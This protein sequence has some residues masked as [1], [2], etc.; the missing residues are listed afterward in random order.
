MS[1]ID[2][3]ATLNNLNIR[4]W[5]EAGQLRFSAPKDAMTE[6][7]R[8]QISTHK[9]DIIAFLTQQQSLEKISIIDDRSGLLALSFAQERLWFLEKLSP[10]NKSLHINSAF[11]IEGE[12]NIKAL[13]R[14]IQMLHQRHSI[15]HY[16]YVQ[17]PEGI[18]VKACAAAKVALPYFDHCTDQQA[19]IKHA[20]EI[21]PNFNLERAELMWQSLYRL[22]AQRHLLYYS[23]HH[24][25]G[26]GLSMAILSQELM[27]CYE[28]LCKNSPHM[29]EKIT[30]DYIDYAA[31]QKKL[32]HNNVFSHQA[33]YWQQQLCD[34]ET[35]LLAS[36]Y[37]RTPHIQAHQ[38]ENG[39]SYYFSLT[40]NL[41]QKITALAQQQQSTLF[42]VLISLWS[43]LLHRYSEQT[44]FCIGTPASN[45]NQSS[46]E[47][48][49]GCFVNMLAI[50]S[51]YQ[52]A[53]SFEQL[54]KQIKQHCKEAF[55][56]QDLPFEHVI[57]DLK[58]S[59]EINS[60]PVFQSLF[61]L[62]QE[63]DYQQTF[64]GISI[65][66]QPLNKMASLYDV[67]LYVTQRS[68]GS[69]LMELI[70]RH[71]LFS[72]S[73]I[74]QMAEHF[75]SLSE[76]L[77]DKPTQ[78]IASHS[79]ISPQQI[80][81]YQDSWRSTE[82][83]YAEAEIG[84]IH[85]LF[86][87]QAEKTPEAIA[88]CCDDEQLSYQ[89]LA[90]KSDSLASQIESY[91]RK[92]LIGIY[93]DRSIDYC[94]AMLGI[95]KTNAA[96]LPLNIHA[97]AQH[98]EKVI[99]SSRLSLIISDSATWQSKL[100]IPNTQVFMLGINNSVT[101]FDESP[102]DL[103]LFNLIYT[104]GSTG[105][106][107]G[108]MV[109]H[110]AIINRLAWMQEAYPLSTKSKVLHKTPLYFDVSVWEVFWPLLNGAQLVIAKAEQHKNSQYLADLIQQQ[111]IS[112]CHFVPA[113]LKVFID[114]LAFYDCTS[115]S[116][117]FSSGEVLNAKL[118]QQFAMSLPHCKLH[119]LY[120]PT[121]AAIDV[122][123]YDCRGDEST[124]PIGS[125][126]SNTQLQII[127][128]HGQLAPNGAIGELSIGGNN[129][130]LGYWNDQQATAKVFIDNP[131][132]S[133]RHPSQTLYKT[134][135]LAYQDA[136]GLLHYIGRNDSQVK[137]RGYRIEL[138][139]VSA[140]LNQLSNID[141]S[142]VKV[143]T[144]D[145]DALLIAYLLN[146]SNAPLNLDLIGKQLAQQLPSYMLP[147]HFIELSQW[148]SFD[149]G[150][151]NDKA[152][153]LP[154][155]IRS[156]QQ[157]YVEPR[158]N[159]EENLQG[160]WQ[161]LLNIDKIGIHDNFFELGGHSLLAVQAIHQ[162]Q[163]YFQVQIALSD[164]LLDPTISNAALLIEQAVNQQNVI[165]SNDNRN[166]DDNEIIL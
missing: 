100:S 103:T 108:V 56:H 158:N 120:G 38:L 105:D 161:T 31:W 43:A 50:K 113:M 79:L 5:L 138:S 27:Q 151:V 32:V 61:S 89:Q 14:S 153:P 97:P 18:F 45:R 33:R 70:Y 149:N 51:C 80:K 65:T 76:A 73:R 24:I 20:Q 137:I 127:N 156:T 21:Q 77:C 53:T 40:P 129:L 88:I 109:P 147:Q 19:A 63:H 107:K 84:N 6:A 99:H 82:K 91:G 1:V 54:L 121:E 68:D 29:L 22:S 66:A 166:D 58:L 141:D 47:K 15:M 25:A 123:Y 85:T 60:T 143:I 93:L 142:R 74:D 101:H 90:E 35:L 7:T 96:Y 13:T 17:T 62:Q 86:S 57:N 23:I 67:S 115:L 87:H 126:I 157:K 16:A 83:D 3:M 39:R 160:I 144:I 4:L 94:I 140:Q 133:Y 48:V 41:S 136:Q 44:V 69:L 71:D 164:V 10:N 165:A 118:A 42:M 102:N 11:L 134:G 155:F 111:R 150:K 95:L 159:I 114:E 81:H 132:L 119:N 146:R 116:H 26:D 92:T 55:A 130:A 98:N 131:L 2:L 52:H 154:S 135:D 12:L 59:R 46:L 152:L 9:T 112:H 148:P 37:P 110:S 122:S 78:A 36:D 72:D 49:F 64:S 139:A 104:S 28:A 145:D 30:T 106:P 125:A 75:I 162:S 124:I 117:V 163:Q 8:K 34:N 128:S